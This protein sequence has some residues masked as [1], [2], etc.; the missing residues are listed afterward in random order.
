MWKN[1]SKLLKDVL[2]P[3]F[4]V[5]CDKEGEWWCGDC[6]NKLKINSQLF[7]PE[8][9]N[10]SRAHYL[11][12]CVCFLS[13][14]DEQS[15]ISRLIKQ[16]K[17]QYAY[18]LET[19]WKNI[20]AKI[21]LDTNIFDNAFLVPVPLN[22]KRYRERGFNQAEILTNLFFD[23]FKNRGIVF[24]KKTVNLERRRYTEQQAKL[25][26]EARFKNVAGAFVCDSLSP[27]PTKIILVD[28]VFTTGATIQECAKILKE[29][30]VQKVYGMTLA[31]G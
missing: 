7:Y 23:K 31:R 2:F 15:A 27:L 29:K 13:Y 4:C 26:R 1:F 24:D 21:N 11:D 30:G 6:L 28:D 5:E 14:K 22:P 19:V 12:G 10:Y 18:D 16:F 20:I 8:E 9:N 17:Y 25:S 3:I